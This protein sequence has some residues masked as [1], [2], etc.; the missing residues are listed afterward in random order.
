MVPDPPP[1][2]ARAQVLAH[3]ARAVGLDR[4]ASSV[5]ELAVLDV[6]LQDTPPGAAAQA[7]AVRLDLAP[8]EAAAAVDGLLDGVDE[9]VHVWSLRGSP[10]VHRR[11]DLPLFAAASWPL[12]DADAVKR[13][14][15]I[16]TEPDRRAP[17][18]SYRLVAEAMHEVVW[19]ADEPR[20]KGTVSTAVTERIPDDLSRYCRGCDAVHVSE[21]LF[22]GTALMAGVRLV[23]G[24][25][26][27]FAPIAGFEAVPPEPDPGAA[28]E[29]AVRYLSLL[30]PGTV[31]EAATFVATRSSDLKPALAALA[32]GELADV[33]ADGR[34]TLFPADE[35]DDLLGAPAFEGVR[36]LPP[37]DPFLRG[38]DRALLVPDPDRRK[39]V[40][41]ILGN[42]GALVVDAEVVGTWR[43][44]KKAKALEVT[45][46]PWGRLRGGA[47]D[48]AVEEAQ[49]IALVRGAERAEVTFS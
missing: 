49:R 2:V 42:P 39:E 21:T 29:V 4:R 8:G 37:G 13:A 5:D 12:S 7:A 20:P 14:G 31:G 41:K 3:R 17:L 34:R 33:D 10:I 18:D 26:M 15:K 46:E 30:G 35:L 47:R 48:E 19:S 43:A 45:V 23:P 32:E 6:G 9:R 11:A 28:A 44:K 24:Q 16:L 40:W 27:A 1:A 38:G 25:A 22:R 36:L